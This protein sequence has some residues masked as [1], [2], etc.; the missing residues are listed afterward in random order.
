M[1]VVFLLSQKAMNIHAHADKGEGDLS[2]DDIEGAEDVL[3]LE[4][5]PQLT[6]L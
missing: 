3:L 2:K 5:K 6:S 4:R 1:A